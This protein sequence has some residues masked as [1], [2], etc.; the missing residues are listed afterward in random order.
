MVDDVSSSH[1][2]STGEYT[3]SALC[4]LYMESINS[5]SPGI[6]NTLD[7]GY[8][9]VISSTKSITST[10]DNPFLPIPNDT[11]TTFDFRCTQISSIQLPTLTQ[12]SEMFDY[13]NK[14]VGYKFMLNK[15][16]LIEGNG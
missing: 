9:I 6:V 12:L 4:D 7:Q 5:I 1:T 10:C 2:I 3:L 8:Q 16:S 11:W 14:D 15:Y 13:F